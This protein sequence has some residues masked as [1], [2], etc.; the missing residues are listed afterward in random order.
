MKDPRLSELYA[1]ALARRA[2]GAGA[3]C[4]PPEQIF[5]LAERTL[6]EAERLRLFDHIMACEDCRREYA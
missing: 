6:P 4:P 3:A 1:E 2:D 5:A